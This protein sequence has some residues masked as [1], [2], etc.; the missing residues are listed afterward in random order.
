MPRHQ[1]SRYT[2]YDADGGYAEYAVVPED[3]AYELPDRYDAVC[4]AQLL[5]AVLIGYR[6]LERAGA[7]EKG[8]LLLVGFGS[9][10]HI[11]PRTKPSD[12]RSGTPA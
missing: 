6:A 7:P 1:D 12:A 11:E 10:A 8:K 3:F 5:C 4:V 2:G 9:S